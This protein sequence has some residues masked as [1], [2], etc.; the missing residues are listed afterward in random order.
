MTSR[1][2]DLRGWSSTP[3]P[4]YLRTLA[5]ATLAGV[6]PFLTVASPVSW[7]VTMVRNLR[8]LR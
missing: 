3:A 4:G 1:P 8:P 6:A 7:S 5:S 2:A